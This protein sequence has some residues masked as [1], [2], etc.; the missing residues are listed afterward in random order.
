[1]RTQ[2][3]GARGNAA[4]E[5]SLEVGV[6]SRKGSGTRGKGLCVV[7]NSIPPLRNGKWIE[8]LSDK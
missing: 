3:V 7:H 6:P 4:L 1:V 5:R 2:Y 8:N